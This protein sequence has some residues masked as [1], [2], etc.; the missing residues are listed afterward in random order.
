MHL[1]NVAV[2]QRAIE[3][4]TDVLKAF[5]LK[6]GTVMKI[7]TDNHTGRVDSEQLLLHALA[8]MNIDG[9]QG[10]KQYVREDILA[11]GRCLKE[12]EKKLEDKYQRSLDRSVCQIAIGVKATNAD[13]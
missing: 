1:L 5:L 8:V 4:L 11:F 9:F 6:M 13:E 12:L 10:L 3:S 7:Y 2:Q